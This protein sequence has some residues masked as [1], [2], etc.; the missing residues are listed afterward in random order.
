MN[1]VIAAA[2]LFFS[3]FLPLL[4]GSAP[5]YLEEAFGHSPR[6][7]QGRLANGFRYAVM[8]HP[9]P[10]GRISVRLVVLAGGLHESPAEWGHAHFVEHM[11]FN[12]TRHFPVGEMIPAF[13][14]EGIVFGQNLGA[15][16][17]FNRTLYRI[18]LPNSREE[19]FGRALLLMEDFASGLL[20]EPKEVEK[21]R[22]VILSERLTRESETSR[23]SSAA[24]SF[25]LSGTVFAD[26][27]LVGTSD[28]I[29]AASPESLRA[30]HDAWYRPENMVLVVIGDIQEEQLIQTIGKQ[31]SVLEP[32]APTRPLP[33]LGSLQNTAPRATVFSR[34]SAGAM[35]GIFTVQPRELIPAEQFTWGLVR[36]GLSR[37][38]A[39]RMFGSRFDR[40]EAKP[41][42]IL[43]GSN[44]SRD[45]WF[46]CFT[47]YSIS[48]FG[49]PSNL[50]ALLALGEQEFRKAV[51]YGFDPG[52]LDQARESLRLG[53]K[54]GAVAMESATSPQI[55]EAVADALAD[56]QTCISF[57]DENLERKLEILDSITVEDCRLAMV[58]GSRASPP[59]LFAAV[60]A[61]VPVTGQNLLTTWQ[62]SAEKPVSRPAEFRALSFAYED[63]GVPGK[64]LERRHEAGLDFHTV[65]FENGVRANLKITPHEKGE[66]RLKI[67]LGQGR[68]AE[69]KD[70]PGLALWA[71]QWLLGGLGRHSKEDVQMLQPAGL[72]TEHVAADEDALGIAAHASSANLKRL[73]CLVTAQITDSAFSP[74]AH[75]RMVASINS[76]VNPLIGTSDL[77]EKLGFVPMLA[78]GDPRFG[79]PAKPVLFSIKHEEVVGWLKRQIAKGRVEVTLVGDLDLEQTVQALAAT[80]G[81]LPVRGEEP[82]AEGL[83]RLSF[84][85]GKRVLRDSFE[86]V[87]DKPATLHFAWPVRDRCD[88]ALFWR[89][90][91]LADV[92]ESRIREQLREE[93]GGLYASSASLWT[94]EW[95]YTGLLYLVC[96]A[97]VQP[98]LLGRMTKELH[99]IASQLRSEGPTRDELERAVAQ[100]LT[101]LETDRQSNLYWLHQVLNGSQEKPLLLE[102]ARD[103]DRILKETSCDDLQLVAKRYLTEES[104][105]RSEI[106]PKKIT[107]PKPAR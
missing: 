59:L 6:I 78:G 26:R 94:F 61:G 64:V 39:L 74:D 37:D 93:R 14:R 53:M 60:Q 17:N 43:F 16:T 1:R 71:G 34:N 9:R 22:G 2:V 29:K 11:A 77:V 97:E 44:C 98:K 4:A 84:E 47:V 45:I 80:L 90:L 24:R 50:P 72:L 54:A 103:A 95:A 13:E 68:L 5:D 55:A 40:L 106:L 30:F 10:E 42:R 35:I 33:D 73:L 69:P 65:V 70:R 62:A 27:Q 23:E 15:A 56:F 79:L 92:L 102:I 83:R 21:E 85:K 99:R 58:E 76:Y 82:A 46:D 52:E 81:T 96:E 7:R 107:L 100:R 67:R 104:L 48:L 89:L 28:S 105:Y 87:K 41:D 8:R 101:R 25:V 57:P 66:F 32:R 36:K 88:A 75:S 20:F 86:T 49:A 12:G 91:L 31:F 51:A 38:L 3:S 18:D 19:L 63:F